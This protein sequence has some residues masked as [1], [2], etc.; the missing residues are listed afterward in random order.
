MNVQNILHGNAENHDLESKTVDHSER[1]SLHVLNFSYKPR[2]HVVKETLVKVR[3][4]IS[5]Y[6]Q[7]WLLP[8]LR[9]LKP[10]QDLILHRLNFAARGGELTVC[11]GRDDE[12][13]ELL[14]L[15]S[16][17]T[18]TGNFDGD[19]ILSGPNVTPSTYYHD[20]VA[21]V[22]S[23]SLSFFSFL[24]FFLLISSHSL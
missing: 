22:P 23:V 9:T 19:I 15:I 7:G 13:R 12:A 3:R 21:F 2:R 6:Y 14:H 17:R 4:E 8:S 5:K 24:L 10:H 16:G 18:K 1:Y 20:Q 11:I